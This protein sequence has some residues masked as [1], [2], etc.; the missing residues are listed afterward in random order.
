MAI[1]Y[2][3]GPPSS[4]TRFANQRLPV[5][6]VE[7]AKQQAR[8]NRPRRAQAELEPRRAPSPTPGQVAAVR[9]MA[10]TS[11]DRHARK[12]WLACV[13]EA[14]VRE[15]EDRERRKMKQWEVEMGERL[16]VKVECV[17]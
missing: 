16:L 12:I 9:R 5:G 13:A 14:A 7:H 15:M 4:R 3:D 8:L 11:L 2:D 10:Q 17:E 6:H 1:Q